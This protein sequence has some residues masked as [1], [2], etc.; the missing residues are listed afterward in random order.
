[1][2]LAAPFHTATEK[3]ANTTKDQEI[4]NWP[5]P[6]DIIADLEGA[7]KLALQ[8]TLKKRQKSGRGSCF[9]NFLANFLIASG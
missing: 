8:C 2:V 1:M 6:E 5:Q 4:A 9:G 7:A 3:I